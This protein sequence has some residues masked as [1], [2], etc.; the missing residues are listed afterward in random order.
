MLI[1]KKSNVFF[2]FIFFVFT[3]SF[4]LNFNNYNGNKF[5]FLFFQATSF[6]LFITAIKKNNSAFEFFTYFFFLLSFWFR[7]NCIL[8]FEKVRVIEGDFDL[9]IT[10]YD[11]TTL[12]IIITFVA[13]IFAS[14]IKKYILKNYS[15]IKQPL[16][17]NTYIK[18]YKRYRHYIFMVFFGFLILIYVSN[19]YYKIYA[20]GLTNT[21]ILPIL[22]YFYSWSLTYGLS[23]ITSLLIYVDFLI[24]KSKKVFILGLLESFF[25][26]LNIFSRTFAISFIAYLRGFLS[27]IE[28]KRCVL[29]KSSI[30]GIVFLFV[31]IFFLSIY[32]VTKLRN[33]KFYTTNVTQSK[34]TIAS[35]YSHIIYLSVNRWVGI[36]ALLAVSQSKNLNFVFFISAWKED[37]DITKKSFYTENFSKEH[38]KAENEK[39]NLNLIVTPG[40]VAFLYYSGSIFFVF[41]SIVILILTCSLIEVLFYRISVNNIILANIIGLSL[42]IRIIHFGYI[43]SNTFNFLLSFFLTLIFVFFVRKLLFKK[44]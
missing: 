18:Y 5:L 31:L 28:F 26:Q 33:Q 27:L 42:A 4:F 17:N 22:K 30:I 20:K 32:S 24:F 44:I 43:P 41:L 8:Y 36:D 29:S 37:K 3:L 38:N 1:I 19:S 21:H 6:A 39:K 14:L 2:I 35:T 10:N 16:I 7:F 15:E 25:T 13:C 9:S 23:V 40:I 11:N 34:Q 12:I